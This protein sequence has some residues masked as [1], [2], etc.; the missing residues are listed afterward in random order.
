VRLHLSTIG[1]FVQ[2][3]S[4]VLI[5]NYYRGPA[6]TAFYQLATQI[7]SAATL[8]TMAISA[9]AYKL[10][11]QHGPEAAWQSQ[12]KLLGQALGLTFGGIIIGY[13]LAPW[14][15]TILAG[16][17][18]APAVPL[19]R[20][21]LWAL[22]GMTLSQLMASQW[23]GRGLFWQNTVLS[24][25]A[26]IVSLVSDFLLIPRYGMSGA[27]VSTLLVYGIAFFVNGVFAFRIERGWRRTQAIQ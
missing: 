10:I 23:I 2:L 6:E 4:S 11:A 1:T 5:L 20:T 18:F 15:V 24:G 16:S 14:M 3:Q 9:V 26:T 21:L 13:Y 25:G 17:D 7:V 8:I 22:L 27:V 12:R 19:T